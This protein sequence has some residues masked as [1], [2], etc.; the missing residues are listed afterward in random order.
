MSDYNLMRRL[1]RHD[2]DT[3]KLYWRE[4]R[5][6]GARAGGEA[7]GPDR[8]GYIK[9]T[10]NRRSYQAHR[11]AWLL[12]YGD[13]PEGQIDHINGVRTDNRLSNLRDVTNRA[14]HQN[15]RCHRNGRL[16]GAHFHKQH[17]RWMSQIRV[18][19]TNKYLGLYDTEQEAHEAYMA[20]LK[21]IAV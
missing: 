1:L 14:N 9:L 12:S 16:V 17:E 2:P 5:R 7:G 3:G 21:E 6:G 8:D 13:W 15:Q 4:H 19:G 20:A 10:V 11:I 18:K